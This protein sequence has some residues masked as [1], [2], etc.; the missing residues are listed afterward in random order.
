MADDCEVKVERKD[1][2]QSLLEVRRNVA[3]ARKEINNLRK[4]VQSI[5]KM[6]VAKFTKIEEILNQGYGRE[7][8]PTVPLNACNQKVMLV[9]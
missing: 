1:S 4:E 3:A 7:G 2:L 9:S 6:F 5:R 8:M